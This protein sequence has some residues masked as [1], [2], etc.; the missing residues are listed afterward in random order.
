MREAH[1]SNESV[2]QRLTAWL[3]LS[4]RISRMADGDHAQS[5]AHEAEAP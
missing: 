3:T 1:I 4:V 5:L 2:H